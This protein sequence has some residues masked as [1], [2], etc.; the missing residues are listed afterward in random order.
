MRQS[1]TLC[2]MN[3]VVH[4]WLHVIEEAT[5]VRIGAPS[6]PSSLQSDHERI[7]RLMRTVAQAEPVREAP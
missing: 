1:A 6:S 7:L 4:P 3:L 5:D 2:S